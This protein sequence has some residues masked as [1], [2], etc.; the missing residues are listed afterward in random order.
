MG[1]AHSTVTF[2]NKQIYVMLTSLLFFILSSSP[3]YS[4][5]VGRRLLNAEIR[6][7]SQGNLNG[8]Y[9]TE[10]NWDRI[11][12]EYFRFPCHLFFHKCL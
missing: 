3:A 1:A 5:A 6:I 2:G 11:S 12:S 9:E 10:W 4:E 8:I 7:R